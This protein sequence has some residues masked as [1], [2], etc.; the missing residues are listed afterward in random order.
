MSEN[1]INR[2]FEK[3]Y[4]NCYDYIYKYLLTK[5]SS[6]ET[7]EDVI[8]SVFLKYYQVVSEGKRILNP[9][10]YILRMAKYAVAD[11]YRSHQNEETRDISEIEIID[12]RALNMLERDTTFTYEE[13][14]SAVEKA[15]KVTY[16]IFVMHFQYGY[17]IEKTAKMLKIP[18]STAKS[19]LYRELKRIKEKLKEGAFYESV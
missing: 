7:V 6:R 9:K 1:Q 14:M 16:Q 19:K 8:Q 15:D 18:Q 12:E 10:H 4:Y 17:T 11:F 3:V 5:L 2:E 13:I